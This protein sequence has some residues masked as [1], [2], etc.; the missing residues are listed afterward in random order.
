MAGGADLMASGSP[1]A[2]ASERG[3]LSLG[4]LHST[5]LNWYRATTASPASVYNVAT[6]V[7]HVCV[8]VCMCM[9]VCVCACVCEL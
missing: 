7:G 9:C 6:Y 1:P 3:V 5:N 4:S 2:P 8:C